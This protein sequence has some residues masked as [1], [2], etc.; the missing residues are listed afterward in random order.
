MFE[1]HKVSAYGKASK[2]VRRFNKNDYVLYYYVGYGVIGVGQITDPEVYENKD[3][4]EEY[5]RVR[6]LTPEV[7]C[8]DDVCFISPS[9][10]SEITGRSFWYASTAKSPY[11][12]EAEVLKVVEVLNAKYDDEIPSF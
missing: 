9:E 2:F 1:N 3:R 8:E 11:L 12:S 7:G 5:R 10:L 6:L 4:D